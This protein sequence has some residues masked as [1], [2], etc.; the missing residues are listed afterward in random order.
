MGVTDLHLCSYDE[1]T[2]YNTG[3]SELLSNYIMHEACVNV[4]LIF[5]ETLVSTTNKI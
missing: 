2:T 3:L 5:Q 1:L 4:R